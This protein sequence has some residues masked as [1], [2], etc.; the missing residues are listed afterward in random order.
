VVANAEVHRAHSTVAQQSNKPV[1]SDPAP[2]QIG[3]R[4]SAIGKALAEC[5]R[6]FDQPLLWTVVGEQRLDFTPQARIALPRLI[7]ELGPLRHGKLERLREDI[8]DSTP[9]FSGHASADCSPRIARRSQAS[10]RRISRITVIPA[11]PRACAVSSTVQPPK[12]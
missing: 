2:D 4:F 11:I 5:G 7:Q 1:G 12:W 6:N 8:F 10:A 3:A 9:A